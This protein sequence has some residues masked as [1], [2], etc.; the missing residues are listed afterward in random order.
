MSC[1]PVCTHASLEPISGIRIFCRGE[2]PVHSYESY[3]GNDFYSSLIPFYLIAV[4]SALTTFRREM[5][6]NRLKTRGESGY[7]A[8]MTVRG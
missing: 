7:N 4:R 6:A 8:I 5:T 1:F 2:P 3:F